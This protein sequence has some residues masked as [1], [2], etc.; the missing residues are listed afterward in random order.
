MPD[1]ENGNQ[2]RPDETTT[3]PPDPG[4]PPPLPPEESPPADLEDT[5]HKDSAPQPD[6]P[7]HEDPQSD[8]DGF[9]TVLSNGVRRRMKNKTADE[10]TITGPPSTT[11]PTRN[12]NVPPPPIAL[13][14]NGTTSVF[15]E[16]KGTSITYSKVKYTQRFQKS[17]QREVFPGKDFQKLIGM[18]QKADPNLMVCPLAPTHDGSS[19]YIDQTCYIPVT[20]DTQLQNYFSHTVSRDTVH[21]VFIIRTSKTIISLKENG[22]IQDFLSKKSILLSQTNWPTEKEKIYILCFRRLRD[23]DPT[24]RLENGY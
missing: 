1:E 8:D 18:L 3:P 4:D 23:F 22:Y 15:Q 24:R 19:N 6:P 7:A 17:K 2:P 16:E 5:S 14:E 21:G 12:S 13:Y 11:L 10:T 9:V 20:D